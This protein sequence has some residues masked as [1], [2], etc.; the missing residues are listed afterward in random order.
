MK[1]AI[2]T[3]S[4]KSGAMEIAE[5]VID[6]LISLGA[7][8]LVTKQDKQKRCTKLNEKEIFESSDVVITIGGDGTLIS[9]AKKAATYG[10]PVLGINAGR[11]GFLTDVE[12]DNLDL[13][14][15]LV[16]GDYTTENRMMIKASVIKNGKDVFSDIAL[17]EVIISGGDIARIAD[18]EVNVG[19]DVISYRADG[20]IISTPTGSTA[21]SMSAG[22]P[23]IDPSLKCY[24]LTPVCSHSLT[25]RPMLINA[26][27]KIKVTIP[28]TSRASVYL[29]IDGARYKESLREQEIVL[30]KCDFDVKLINISGKTIFKTL[31]MKF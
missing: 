25:A 24:N 21:Y 3:N 19:K 14:E 28:E 12:K 10:K 16:K 1:V 6:K 27:E 31:S 20:I 15:K 9:Y 17:N 5:K 22:G 13:L 2:F 7:E 23:I 8:V 11:L 26:N 29:G 18:I 30:S 4:Q